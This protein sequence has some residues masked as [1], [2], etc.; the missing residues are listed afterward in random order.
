MKDTHA[1]S[2]PDYVVEIMGNQN[3]RHR[4]RAAKVRKLAAQSAPGHPIY[5]RKRLIQQQNF[6]ST[7]ERAGD[8]YPLLLAPREECGVAILEPF[9]MHARKQRAGL[10]VAL[11]GA[12]ITERLHHVLDGC[13]VGKERVGLEHHADPAIP[14]RHADANFA[15]EP[16]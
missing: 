12:K 9:E 6:G 16:D 2:K 8:R 14:C 5:G 4:Q 11:F 7:C 10:T 13:Q 3:H 1:V 15:V